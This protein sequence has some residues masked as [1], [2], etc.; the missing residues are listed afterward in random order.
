M[1]LVTFGPAGGEQPGVLVGADQVLPTQPV[2]ARAGVAAHS[3]NA[4]LAAWPVVAPLVHA[5]LDDATDLIPLDGLRLGPPVPRPG[6]I[7]AIGFNYPQHADG[8][9]AADA[10][11]TEPVVFL[12][13]GSAISGPTDPIVKPPE[14][15]ALD[16]EIELGVVIGRAGHRIPRT[17]ALDHVAGYV[18]AN[19]L[20]ARDVALGAGLEHPLLLQ[21]AR[22]KGYPTFCPTGPWLVTPDELDLAAGLRLELSVNGAVRQLG[23]TTDMAVDVAG[24]IASVSTTVPLRPGDLILTGTPPGCGFQLDP[25]AYLNAGDKIRASITGLG[26]MELTVIDENTTGDPT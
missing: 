20:T 14:T 23:S 6:T 18:L 15:D 5:A 21:I 17:E 3:V 9:V 4:I 2:L 22:G 19:D 16:Y 11:R 24:L 26:E 8:I 7:I 25:P 12:K 1:K 13:P 10:P